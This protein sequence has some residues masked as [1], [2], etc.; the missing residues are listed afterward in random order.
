MLINI[1]NISILNAMQ[2][3]QALRFG[4]WATIS[5][6]LSKSVISQSEIGNYEQVMM[7]GTFFSFFWINSLFTNLL[8]NYHKNEQNKSQYFSTTFLIF[9]IIN[10]IFALLLFALKSK[11]CFLLTGSSQLKNYNVML[12]LYYFT[13][14]SFFIE[15]NFLLEKKTTQLIVY[16]IANFTL[17]IALIAFSLYYLKSIYYVF[18]SIIGI[19]IIKIPIVLYVAQ[20]L[21]FKFNWTLFKQI[22]IGISPL[23]ISFLISGSNEYVDKFMIS[24]FFDKSIYA[25]YT[26]GAREFIIATILAGSLSSATLPLASSNLKAG[27]QQLK[28]KSIHYVRILFPIAMIGMFMTFYL[29]PFVLNKNFETTWLI[30]NTYLL[31]LIPRF[32]FPQVI[33]NAVGKNKVIIVST[34]LEILAN[35]VF[36][37]IFYPLIGIVGIALGPVIGFIVDKIVQIVYCTNYLKINMNEYVHVK[38]YL[39]WTFLLSLSYVLSIITFY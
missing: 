33:I 19:S 22:S 8:A 24:H 7:I 5:I 26:Y 31:L 10:S 3:F 38:E 25:Q 11:I 14:F 4:T 16:A 37:C 2:L 39:F 15:H 17:T 35:I 28:S 18:I 20:L 13:N 27:M 32:I 1:K 29:F 12:L 36:V 30:S 23:L 34:C 6:M 9:V 21:N